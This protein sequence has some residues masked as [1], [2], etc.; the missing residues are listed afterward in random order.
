MEATNITF[1]NDLDVANDNYNIKVRIIRLWTQPMFN[2]PSE[3]YS[4]EM[5]LMDEQGTKMQ[6]N[7]LKKWFSRFEKFLKENTTL[8]I[9]KPTLGDISHAKYKYVENPIKICLNWNTKVKH[10]EAFDGPKYGFNFIPFQSIL[11]NEILENATINVIGYI[12]KCFKLEN[13][14]GKDGKE[15]KK[16]KIIIEDLEGL[17]MNITLW[18]VYAEEMFGYLSNK[19]DEVHVV[20]ILQ[21]GV[22]KFFEEERVYACSNSNCNTE[23]IIAIPRFKIPIRVQDCTGVVS[24]NLFEREAKRIL[25]KSAN[26]LLEKYLEGGYKGI[27]PDEFND[28]MEKRFAF[29]IDVTNFNVLNNY[30]FFGISKM[31]DDPEIISEL[32]KKFNIDEVNIDIG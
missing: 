4:I 28:L 22:H 20:I 32:E 9:L 8:I 24:L 6:G 23:F 13:F 10:Y 18:G 31:S 7:V 1:L 21:F 11:E 17:K 27:L 29:K 25:K 5:I 19:P 30:K 15:S 26:D 16:I 14:T 2:N 12:V 3:T